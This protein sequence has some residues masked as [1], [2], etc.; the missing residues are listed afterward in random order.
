MTKTN[1]V[2]SIIMSQISTKFQWVHSFGN[3]QKQNLVISITMSQTRPAALPKNI[4]NLQY[5]NFDH[6]F[7]PN[8]N[9]LPF[10]CTSYI[11]KQCC[12]HIQEI[13]TA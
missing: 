13:S 2:I 11:H 4:N 7:T 1:V 9:H 8:T 12:E 5:I 6:N 3:Q 10:F